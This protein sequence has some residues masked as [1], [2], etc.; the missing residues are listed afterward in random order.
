VLFRSTTTV[1]C[2][3]SSLSPL[4][5]SQ[6]LL[7]EY[8]QLLDDYKALKNYKVSAQPHANGA[9]SASTPV[10]EK[11]R[12]RNPYVLVLVDGNGYVV[13]TLDLTIPSKLHQLIN[14]TVQR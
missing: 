8:S 12:N 4:K 10:N 2:R 6:T 13:R 11:P 14:R 7:K 1:T 9:S 5:T 3:W